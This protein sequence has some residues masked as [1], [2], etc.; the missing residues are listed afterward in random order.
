MSRGGERVHHYSVTST[1]AE[2][3]V[4][5]ESG[6]IADAQGDAVRPRLPSSA[7]AS[8]TGVGAVVR[9]AQGRAGRERRS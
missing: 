2:Y 6:A 1:H 9:K 8:M 5:P 7:A 4:V 3:T